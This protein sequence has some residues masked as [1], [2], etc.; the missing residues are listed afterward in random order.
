M[1]Y[2]IIAVLVILTGF[3]IWTAMDYRRQKKD[4][5]KDKEKPS[6]R[7]E[8]DLE[9]YGKKMEDKGYNPVDFDDKG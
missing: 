4:N 2:F 6:F 3:F 1:W 5:E 9:E 7:S 8:Q